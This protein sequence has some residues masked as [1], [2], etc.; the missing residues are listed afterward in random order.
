MTKAQ[1]LKLFCNKFNLEFPEFQVKKTDNGVYNCDIV[2]YGEYILKNNQFT[3][4]NDTV[5]SSLLYLAEWLDIDKNFV[6]LC[7]LDKYEKNKNDMKLT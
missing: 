3:S 1:E 5:T 4:E 7:M 6:Y 2:W